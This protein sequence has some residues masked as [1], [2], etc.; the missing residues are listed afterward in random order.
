MYNSDC[1]LRRLKRTRGT[2][3]TLKTESFWGLKPFERSTFDLARA[4]PAYVSCSNTLAM[5]GEDSRNSNRWMRANGRGITCWGGEWREW[6]KRNGEKSSW[7]FCWFF[8]GN[9]A[10][11]NFPRC[12]FLLRCAVKNTYWQDTLHPFASLLLLLYEQISS[13]CEL[14]SVSE[15][16]NE[17]T[18]ILT[19]AAVKSKR[20]LARRPSSDSEA[21]KT[22][23]SE[24]NVPY[25]P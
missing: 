22:S 23:I 12:R 16:V 25:L 11:W 6:R 9:A 8:S 21:S 5:R 18:A 24:I 19:S 10:N 2:V 13:T 14:T 7:K 15:Q 4:I 1:Y 20:A 17:A 3:W